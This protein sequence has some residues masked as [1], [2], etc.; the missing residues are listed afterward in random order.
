MN[1]IVAQVEPRYCETYREFR[2]KARIVVGASVKDD[3]DLLLLP[4]MLGMWM[5][6]VGF[7]DWWASLYKRTRAIPRLRRYTSNVAGSDS[8]VP[9]AFQVYGRRPTGFDTRLD[10]SWWDRVLSGAMG[11]LQIDR[12]FARLRNN[13]QVKVYKQIFSELAEQYGVAIQAGS[14]VEYCRGG[15]YNV[16]YTFGHDGGIIGRQEKVHPLHVEQALGIREGSGVDVFEVAGVKCGVA[17][18]ADANPQNPH[19]DLLAEEGV[20]FICCPSGGW[21]PCY[22]W[23][24]D[25]ERDMQHIKT[26]V[27]AGVTMG[28]SYHA[29]RLLP[30]VCFR[31]R[32]SIVDPDGWVRFTKS[33]DRGV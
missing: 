4:E 3:T 29:G 15:F 16:A 13:K 8:A 22:G 20:E 21:A 9:A 5:S 28:R 12:L 11:F 1:V 31:G 6:G 33:S 7:K 18:C 24:W 17:I 26:A 30:G 10:V 14:I 19:V 2:S 32:S 23:K 27:R 25:W